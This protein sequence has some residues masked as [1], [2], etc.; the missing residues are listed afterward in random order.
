MD[1]ALVRSTPSATDVE[2]PATPTI[3]A[4]ISPDVDTI[5]P[6]QKVEIPAALKDPLNW[7]AVADSAVV[8]WSILESAL[9]ID[10]QVLNAIEFSTADHI[11]CGFRSMWAG[12]SSGCGH[13]K[14]SDVGSDSRC[15]VGRKC[16]L[17]VISA[18]MA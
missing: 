9:K 13:R 12:D 1:T 14:R 5:A 4:T 18:H 11:H 16:G 6:D 10:P 15:D 2:K 7:A 3:D 17:T 8:G